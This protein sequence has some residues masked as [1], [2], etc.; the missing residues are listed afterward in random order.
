MQTRDTPDA[1]CALPAVVGVFPRRKTN[2]NGVYKRGRLRI[3]VDL[4]S[5][6]MLF[7]MRQPEAAKTL[8]ISLTALKQVCRKL[9]IVRWP[10]RRPCIRGS[11]YKS[12]IKQDAIAIDEPKRALKLHTQPGT[13]EVDTHTCLGVSA[14]LE[15]VV[16]TLHDTSHPKLTTKGIFPSYLDTEGMPQQLLSSFS[17]ST[18]TDRHTTPLCFLPEEILSMALDA[19]DDDLGWLFSCG[20]LDL[21][22]VV[23]ELVFDMIWRERN[24]LEA[25][26]SGEW[27]LCASLQ[28]SKGI[29]LA[30]HRWALRAGTCSKFFLAPSKTPRLDRANKRL[31]KE[32]ILYIS[33]YIWRKRTSL[34]CWVL[35]KL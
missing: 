32:L 18:A 24:A 22:P 15:S 4:D 2:E 35:L 17:V 16:S 6:R 3:S 5:I 7:G 21:H 10:Y 28:L 25:P 30:S 29:S 34:K 12:R 8:T 33:R 20:N 23:E 13:D 11:H 14:D 19:D 26:E 31:N 9:G 27:S 1:R